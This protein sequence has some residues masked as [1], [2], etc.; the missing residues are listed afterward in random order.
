MLR[1]FAS[2]ANSKH[3]RQFAYVARCGSAGRRTLFDSRSDL[4]LF[5]FL[6]TDVKEVSRAATSSGIRDTNLLFWTTGNQIKEHEVRSV[7]I[8][9]EVRL[10]NA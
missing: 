6:R 8:D 3:D 1:L 9:E 2:V 4:L 10:M 7:H 5:R